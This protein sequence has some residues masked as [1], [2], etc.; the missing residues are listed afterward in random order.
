MA[1]PHNSKDKWF[2][3]GTIGIPLV[4]Y[5]SNTVFK[6]SDT[7]ANTSNYFKRFEY[8]DDFTTK[9]MGV[10]LKLGIIYRP[11]DYI[12]LGLA[13]HTPT[14]MFLTDTRTS[15]LTTEVENP[16]DNFSVSSQTFTNDQPGKANYIQSTVESHHQR[17]LCFQGDLRCKKTKRIYQRRY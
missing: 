10:N 6:E 11:Q 8:T 16:V 12:R 4:S 9:G 7:S 1:L 17:F 3:G 13:I 2:I 15:F 5:S 14:W